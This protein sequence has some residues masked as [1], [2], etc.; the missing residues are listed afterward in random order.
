MCW[1][2]YYV[3]NLVH[4]QA[5]DEAKYIKATKA[6]RIKQLQELHVK[7]DERSLAEHN[8]WKTFEEDMTSTLNMIVSSDDSRKAAFQ[9]AYDEDQQIVAVKSL[10]AIIE[11][12]TPFIEFFSL[13]KMII[14]SKFVFFLPG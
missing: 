7:I 12:Y 11:S 4:L 1:A 13:I 10:L 5:T 8:Q 3:K 14:S 6:D 2:A 9:L